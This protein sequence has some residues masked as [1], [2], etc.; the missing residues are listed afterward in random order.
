MELNNI[1]AKYVIPAKNEPDKV[2]C[3][4]CSAC[5]GSCCKGQGC[6][7]SP[8]D[9]KEIT[10]EAI[11]AFIDEA[12]CISID[13]WEGNPVTDEHTS[14]MRVYYL[15]IKNKNASTL[16][17]AMGPKRCG[18]LTDTGCPIDF[19]YRPKGARELIPNMDLSKECFVNYSKQQC[20]IDWMKYQNVLEQVYKHYAELEGEPVSLVDA[21]SQLLLC[22]GG[23]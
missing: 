13:W 6:H 9:L 16:D 7:I 3:D 21:F 22:L 20:C 17:P 18:L 15:R 4:I 11:I 14:N 10:P 8:D 23:I 5:S 12:K 1:F 19:I 2:N